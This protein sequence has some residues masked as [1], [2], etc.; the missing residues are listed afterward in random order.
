MKN[1]IVRKNLAFFNASVHGPIQN[2]MVLPCSANTKKA[3]LLLCMFFGV[4][5]QSA[6]YLRAL[7]LEISH[8]A[9]WNECNK[10]DPKW[11]TGSSAR[12][13]EPVIVN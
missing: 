6:K 12:I 11:H 5:L 10:F 1:Q 8:L 7:T 9:Q 3:L 13:L 2:G 4:F